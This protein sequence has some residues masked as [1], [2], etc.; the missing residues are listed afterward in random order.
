[1][2]RTERVGDCLLCTFGPE[3]GYPRVAGGARGVVLIAHRVVYEH[4]HGQLAEGQ[5]IRH[6]CD[7]RNCV[8]ISHLLAGTQADNIHDMADRGR[9]WW[10]NEETKAERLPKWRASK[11]PKE[12]TT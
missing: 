7:N 8:E 3:V 11:F 9:A 4:H 1:M 5:V 2:D 6:T 12:G 10:Q